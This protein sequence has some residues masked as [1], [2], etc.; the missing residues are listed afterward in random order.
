MVRIVTDTTAVLPPQIANRYKIP[1]LPQLIHFE[2]RTFVEGKDIDHQTFLSRLKSS[3]TLPKTAAP[4]PDLFVE[5]FQRIISNEDQI[6]CI[7]PSAE[8]SGTVRSASVASQEFPET[9]IRVVDT[10]LVASPLGIVVHRAA[11]WAQE[12]FGIEE[13]EEKVHDFASTGVIYF[14]VATLDFLARGGRIGG[15]SALIGNALKLKPI[16]TLTK[17]KVEPFGKERTTKRA[18]RRLK[19]LVED[20]YPRRGEGY[21]TIMHAD[22]RDTALSLSEHFQERLDIPPPQISHLPPAIITHAG[23]GALGIGFFKESGRS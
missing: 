11:E 3:K 13:L 7:H 1:I 19:T 14:L 2:D 9:D 21:L 12:G 18:L 15:A 5:E 20:Q 10:R 8:L 6:L 17:G 23:P 16:L 4:P 22:V